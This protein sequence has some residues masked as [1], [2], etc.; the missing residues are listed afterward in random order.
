MSESMRGVLL[1]GERR[2]LLREFARPTP[3][4]GQ[5]LVRMRASSICGSDIRAIYREHLGHGPEAYQGVIAG[6]EP[7]GEIVEI[8]PGCRRFRAGDRVILYHISGCGVC[9]DCRSGYLISCTAPERRAYGWQ[10]DGGHAD[11]LLADEQTCVALPAELSFVDGALVACGF[12]TAYEALLR[13]RVGGTDAMLITGLGP[14]GLAAGLLARKMG[15]APILGAD[16]SPARRELALAVGAV[17]HAL[18]TGGALERVRELTAGLGC[19][20]AVDCSG[21]AAG[22]TLAVHA[23]RRWGRVALVG[24]GGRLELDASAAL[25]HNQISLHGSWVTSVPHMEEL[26]EHLVRWQLRPEVTVTH[27][28]SLDQAD[29]AY[30]IADEGQC[31]KVCIV[32]G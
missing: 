20:V 18:D 25:I 21:A 22:R 29:A 5:V 7:C 10:R 24:E 23:T 12:G 2:V 32:M 9:W 19:E 28:F 31:G 16:P 11:Y 17:D 27:R 14:V 6:H 8:G 26:V 30:R 4:H 3:G 13:V 1:P 15:A